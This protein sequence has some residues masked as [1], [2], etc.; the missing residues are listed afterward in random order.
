MAV[1][2]DGSLLGRFTE[3]DP[4]TLLDCKGSVVSNCNYCKSTSIL[5]AP[6]KNLWFGLMILSQM[7]LMSVLCHTERH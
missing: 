1:K 2:E 5:K 4:V 3:L 7:I 6:E